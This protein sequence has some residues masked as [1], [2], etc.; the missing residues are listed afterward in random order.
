MEEKNF[1]DGYSYIYI[2]NNTYSYEISITIGSTKEN[3]IM[4]Q[5]LNRIDID[6]CY[7]WER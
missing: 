2:D 7:S 1:Y 4:Q 6:S 5:K 3:E